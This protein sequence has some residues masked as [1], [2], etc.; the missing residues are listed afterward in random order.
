MGMISLAYLIRK[1]GFLYLII[2]QNTLTTVNI[3]RTILI[4]Y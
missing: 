3:P 4:S 2:F 1:V